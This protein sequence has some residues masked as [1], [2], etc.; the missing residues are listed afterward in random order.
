MPN[1]RLRNAQDRALVDPRPLRELGQRVKIL[2]YLESGQSQPEPH[3]ETQQEQIKRKGA[4]A[5]ALDSGP[6]DTER[7]HR[8]P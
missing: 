8:H 2:M 3:E 1:Q 6:V 4:D 5:I 7:C